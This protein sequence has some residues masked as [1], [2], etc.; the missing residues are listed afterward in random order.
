MN[1]L[2]PIILLSLIL[3]SCTTQN[4]HDLKIPDEI[5]TKKYADLIN[6]KGTSVFIKKPKDF[7]L[8]DKS[9]RIQKNTKTYI[10]II[11]G[12]VSNFKNT[13]TTILKYYDTAVKNGNLTKEYYK[14]DFKL[15][16]FNAFIYYG[17]DKKNN[18]EKITF[19]FG[20]NDFAVLIFAVFPKNDQKARN[21]ILKT[22]LSVYFDKKQN[23][24]KETLN[25]FN[26]DVVNTEFLYTESRSQLHYY[27]LNGKGNPNNNFESQIIVIVLPG[28][29]KEA[30]KNYS[31]ETIKI[32]KSKGMEIPKYSEKEIFKKDNFGYEIYFDGKFE[33][34]TNSV[35]QIVLCNEKGSV[36][37][38]GIV[39]DR[40]DEL[41]K[42][43]KTI[44]KTFKLK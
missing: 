1:K 13:K 5:V 6:F 14:K 44:A 29:G 33:G 25:N 4:N 22:I 16:E 40:R 10:E 35:Y 26:L 21:N 8:V 38:F 37:F 7:E 11:E 24:E 36:A 2:I 23:I 18:S 43:I 12:S 15:N 34:K 30:I 31:L 17:A 9:L 28:I 3:M 19:V 41:M 39:Y 32:L 20:D 27:T 42:Q